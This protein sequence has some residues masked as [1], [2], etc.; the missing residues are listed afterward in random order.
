VLRS[1]AREPTKL[2]FPQLLRERRPP[3]P[4]PLPQSPPPPTP[5][6]FFVVVA[7]LRSPTA[8]HRSRG[9]HQSPLASQ[10]FSFRVARRVARAFRPL[11][12]FYPALINCNITYNI[13]ITSNSRD[14]AIPRHISSRLSITV[15]RRRF[16]AGRAFVAY[17][18]SSPAVVHTPLSVARMSRQVS[19]PL[20]RSRPTAS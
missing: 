1:D 16:V 6:P 17:P 15:C 4:P 12:L 7:V 3:H 10:S 14:N 20:R 8:S 13:K 11:S 2:R 9:A 5:T 18:S 19:S